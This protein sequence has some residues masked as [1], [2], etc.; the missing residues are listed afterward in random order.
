M[1]I[2]TITRRS[3]LVTALAVAC[4]ATTTDTV[5]AADDPAPE[6]AAVALLDEFMKALA[7][8]VRT[9]G[10]HDIVNAHSRTHGPSWRMIVS[11]EP[12]ARQVGGDDPDVRLRDEVSHQTRGSIGLVAPGR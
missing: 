6:P 2:K 9:G 11:L 12:G 3:L 8:P 1:N 10:N 5:L 4:A 7:I